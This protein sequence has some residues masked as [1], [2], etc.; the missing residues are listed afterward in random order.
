MAI[1]SYVARSGICFPQLFAYIQKIDG[2]A[3]RR[4]ALLLVYLTLATGICS[5]PSMAETLRM[6]RPAAMDAATSAFVSKFVNSP[7]LAAADIEIAQFATGELVPP[8]QDVI[9]LHEKKADLALVGHHL[10]APKPSDGPAISLLA[11]PTIVASAS[12]KFAIQDSRFGDRIAAELGGKSLLS[13]AYWD[14]SPWAILSKRPVTAWND[15]RGQKIVSY[16]RS[17]LDLFASVGASPIQIPA[18]EVFTALERGVADASEILPS[19]SRADRSLFDAFKGGAVVPDFR[20]S[21]GFLAAHQDTWIRITERQR[22]ALGNAAR[23]AEAIARQVVLA[24][25]ERFPATL[26]ES[27]VELVSLKQLG[28]LPS[29]LDAKSVWLRQAGDGGRDVLK[30]LEDV[31]RELINFRPPQRRGEIEPAPS[32]Q[33]LFATVRNDEGAADLSERFGIRRADNAPLSCGRVAYAL[34]PQRKIGEEY[35]GSIMLEPGTSVLTNQDCYQLLGDQAQ[36][37]KGALFVYV[38]GFNN[39]LAFAV[40]RAIGLATD[41][42]MSSPIIA[43]SWPSANN[44]SLY[45]YDEGS[46]TWSRD[47]FLEFVR[48]LLADARIKRLTLLSHSMGGRLAGMGLEV[49]EGHPRKSIVANVVFA[50]P[51]VIV[52]VFRHA[53]SRYGKGPNRI[54][55]YATSLDR[56]LMYSRDNIHKDDLAGLGGERVLVLSNLET[57]DASEVESFWALNHAYAFDHAEVLIDLQKLVSDDIPARDRGL[58]EATKGKGSYWLIPP[59]N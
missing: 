2:V 17:A 55:L 59:P 39:S 19:V 6:I 46:V 56:A 1:W 42:R 44:R 24:E 11:A 13:L 33:V 12:E 30:L 21:M 22:Q 18:G 35:K 52:P 54:T 58:R 28:A 15:L 23:D 53:I 40:K 8:G 43:W 5:R 45:P 16:D 36:R 7:A 14:R 47:Y 9:A 48:A 3:M 31:Q 25:V 41:L 34:P 32:A 51:D 29:E 57:V 4:L 27:R 20:Q 49:I 37:S 26:R 50:A 38:H 10:I